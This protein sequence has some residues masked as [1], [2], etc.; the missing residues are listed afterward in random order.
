MALGIV[1]DDAVVVGESVYTLRSR[2]GDTLE[3]TIKGTLRVALPTLFGVF[4][5]V[6]AF[7]AISRTSGH[8]GEIYAQ[9][10]LVVAICLI[11]FDHRVETDSARAH[12][13]I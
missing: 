11:L 3:N 7:Y 9:F 12:W 1:V 8:L 2:D 10:A 6:A 4:T 13:H 5:T